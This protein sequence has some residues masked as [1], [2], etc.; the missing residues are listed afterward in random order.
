MEK[1]IRD[2]ER[3]RYCQE[4]SNHFDSFDTVVGFTVDDTVDKIQSYE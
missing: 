3:L 2:F 1:Y 4:K